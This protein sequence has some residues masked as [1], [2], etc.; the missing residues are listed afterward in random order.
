MAKCLLCLAVALALVWKVALIVVSVLAVVLL[1]THVTSTLF[2]TRMIKLDNQWV[3]FFGNRAYEWVRHR[4]VLRHYGHWDAVAQWG[5]AAVFTIFSDSMDNVSSL[6]FASSKFAYMLAMAFASAIAAVLLVPA[7]MAPEDVSPKALWMLSSMLALF[8]SAAGRIAYYFGKF[9]IHTEGL[10]QLHVE[11]SDTQSAVAKPADVDGACRRREWLECASDDGSLVRRC[12]AE[13]LDDPQVCS[14]D[15]MS[16]A[17]DLQLSKPTVDGDAD[18]TVVQS[19]ASSPTFDG[20]SLGA[21][22]LC[23]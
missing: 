3:E 20:G 15:S 1:L 13:G 5:T 22:K 23:M 9:M 4:Q 14:S 10:R 19:A 7:L 16:P 12:V 17:G 6:A 18:S 11:L 8:V 2:Y 21:G